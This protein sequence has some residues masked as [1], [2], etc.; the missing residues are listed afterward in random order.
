MET[1]SPARKNKSNSCKGPITIYFMPPALKHAS[2]PS[3]QPREAE[4]VGLRDVVGITLTALLAIF[5]AVLLISGLKRRA[6]KFANRTAFRAT[7]QQ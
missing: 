3:Q 2:S 6:R 4:E 5:A 1:P 7:K